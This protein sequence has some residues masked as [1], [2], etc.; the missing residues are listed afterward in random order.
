M[1]LVLVHLSSSIC[2]LRQAPFLS[3][4]RNGRSF[5]FLLVCGIIA[6]SLLQLKAGRSRRGVHPSRA[7]QPPEPSGDR[8]T[9]IPNGGARVEAP[10]RKDLIRPSTGGGGGGDP[11]V[12]RKKRR[13]NDA[14][15]HTLA[16]RNR[17]APEDVRD[18]ESGSRF[19]RND[20]LSFRR[21]AFEVELPPLVPSRRLTRS[22]SSAT[23]HAATA[24]ATATAASS[25]FRP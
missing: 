25:S 16:R 13:S 24:T 1:S 12:G 17:R 14:I 20:R 10:R 23:S 4:A 5:L 3:G 7:R 22:E 8:R 11:C 9:Q 19:S 6:Q 2:H 21:S 18:G 15:K